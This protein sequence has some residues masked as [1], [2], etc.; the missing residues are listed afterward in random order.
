MGSH[1]SWSTSRYRVRY[2]YLSNYISGL[3]Q[4]E[5]NQLD[6]IHFLMCSNKVNA[7]ELA[8]PVADSLV[9][10]EQSVSM[11]DVYVF[12]VKSPCCCTCSVDHSR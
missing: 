12:E 5:R 3:P 2:G 1:Y 9:K 7:L 6:N 4:S 10:L 11:F 8:K